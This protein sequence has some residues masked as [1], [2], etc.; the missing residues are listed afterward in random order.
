MASAD[1]SAAEPTNN[2]KRFRFHGELDFLS[3]THF[4]P[5]G[6]G[7]NIN[8]IGFGFGRPTGVDAAASRGILGYAPPPIWSLGFGYVFLDGNAIVGGRFAFNLDSYSTTT[9]NDIGERDDLR[10][11]GISGQFIPYFRYLFLPG[12]RLRPYA[13][14]RLGVGGGAVKQRV[15]SNPEQK[16]TTRVVY[17][18]VGLGG[19]VHFFI[20]DAFS[21]DA[22]LTFDY[23][24]PHGKTKVEAGDL[25]VDPDLEK[26]GDYINVAAQ[27]GFSAWF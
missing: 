11:T 25:S 7:D 6:N 22:G 10:V 9:S 23:L 5:D 20:V 2:G 18:A 15:D 17:P 4:N 21:V 16:T 8:G 27:V 19:G 24:A 3:F 1:A 14:A 13:E 26:V 12:K